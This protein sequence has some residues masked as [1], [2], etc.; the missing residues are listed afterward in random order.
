MATPLDPTRRVAYHYTLRYV[1]CD[2]APKNVETKPV[3]QLFLSDQF[4]RSKETGGV[5]NVHLDED[6]LGKEYKGVLVGSLKPEY[7]GGVPAMAGIG[8]HSYAVHRNDFGHACYVNV[9]K[10]CVFASAIDADMRS[11]GYYDHTH[12]LM[13]RTVVVAG[14][15]PVKKGVVQLRIDKVEYAPSLS[16]SS[17]GGGNGGK[18][19][20]SL[21]LSTPVEEVE[22]SMNSYIQSCMALESSMPDLLPGTERVRAPMNISEVGAEFTGTTFMPVVGFALGEV[23]VANAEFF[24]NAFEVVMDRRRLKTSDYYDFDEKEKCRTLACIISNAIQSFDYIGD[25]VELS[26]RRDKKT[27]T[28]RQ[29]V[30]S[31]EFSGSALAQFCLDCEDGAKGIALV[32]RAL[33]ATPFDKNDRRQRPLHEMQAILRDHYK[34]MLVLSIVH[35]A[36]IGDQEGFGAHMYTLLMPN[37]YV[38]HGLSQSQQGQQLLSRMRPPTSAPTS[39]DRLMEIGNGAEDPR[40]LRPVLV[41]EGT[42][43]IDPIGV[44]VPSATQK[45]NIGAGM[46]DATMARYERYKYVATNMPAFSAFK[47]EIPR[48][49]GKDSPFYMANYFAVSSDWIDQ[50]GINVGGFV[51]GTAEAAGGGGGSASQG[52]SQEAHASDNTFAGDGSLSPLSRGILFTDTINH[53]PKLALVPQPPVPPA[54]MQMIREGIA[55]NE[56]A[57]SLVIDRS[58]PLA[59]PETHPLWDQLVETTARLQRPQGNKAHG[60]VDHIVRPHQFDAVVVRRMMDDIARA[61]RVWAVEYKKEQLMTNAYNWRVMLYVH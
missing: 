44:A 43:I 3:A 34:T 46:S 58:K 23:P 35:G 31:E 55:F 29:H 39:L 27:C 25:A 37:Y 18:I 12:D 57:R 51:F 33:V 53:S 28:H 45:Q 32:G 42:G 41:C 8:I 7:T 26:N 38:E 21:L 15:E 40:E 49:E 10:A 61:D 17:R 60:S 22:T 1:E 14:L 48:F 5:H 59:G 2:L 20:A 13:M 56:P 54:V 6:D 19:Q 36:K 50:Y 47:R 30:P 16:A 52:T 24:V 4:V 11:K 9:G